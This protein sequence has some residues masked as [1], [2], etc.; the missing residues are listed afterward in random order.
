MVVVKEGVRGGS[1]DEEEGMWVCIVV[2]IWG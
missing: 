1:G 2:G